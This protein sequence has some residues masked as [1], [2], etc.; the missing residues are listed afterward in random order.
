MKKVA[1]CSQKGGLGKTLLSQNLS[2]AAMQAGHTVLINGGTLC[3]IDTP[4]IAEAAVRDLR[5]PTLTGV[6]HYSCRTDLSVA[7]PLE[8]L[9]ESGIIEASMI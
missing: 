2:V 1:V 4:P 3:I 5:F 6:D 8:T 9:Q 7:I